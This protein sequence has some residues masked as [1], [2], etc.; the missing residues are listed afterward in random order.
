M[1]GYPTSPVLRRLLR[2][3]KLKQAGEKATP[4][5]KEKADAKET[6]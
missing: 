2:R 3:Q 4:K 5:P 6:K 1:A